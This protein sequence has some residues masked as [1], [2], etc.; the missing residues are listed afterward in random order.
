MH[1][2]ITASKNVLYFVQIITLAFQM[3]PF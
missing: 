3:K 1:K 2:Q